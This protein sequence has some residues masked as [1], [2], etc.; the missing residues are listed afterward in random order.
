MEELQKELCE[1]ICSINEEN[2]LLFLG[3]IISD[4]LLDCQVVCQQAS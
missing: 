1:M 4:S 2:I 3:E